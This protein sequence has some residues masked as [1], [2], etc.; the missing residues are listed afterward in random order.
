MQKYFRLSSMVIKS[1]LLA[2]AIYIFGCS[3]AQLPTSPESPTSKIQVLAAHQD[4][5]SVDSAKVFLDG[6]FVGMTPFTVEG[7]AEGQ[8][9]LRVL[10]EGFQIFTQSLIVENG[11]SYT[12]E[13][14]LT[15]L[16]SNDMPKATHPF[17]III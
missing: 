2:L 11:I 8:H 13:A 5:S 15:P 3:K 4:G 16:P 6:E 7:V 1:G 10:K 17:L 12:V 14:V 9:A